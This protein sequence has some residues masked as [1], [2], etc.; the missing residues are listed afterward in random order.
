M[1]PA[2]I[3]VDPSTMNTRQPV[4]RRRSAWLSPAAMQESS[5]GR[6]SLLTVGVIGAVLLGLPAAAVAA[7]TAETAKTAGTP[8]PVTQATQAVGSGTAMRPRATAAVEQYWTPQR[9]TTAKPK[10]APP[11]TPSQRARTTSAPTGNPGGIAPA[12][13]TRT[14]ATAPRLGGAASWPATYNQRPT[15]IVG[16]VFFT[17]NAGVNY[18]CSGAV[19]NSESKLVVWTA[20]HC[21]FDVIHYYC[22]QPQGYYHNWIFVPGYK[23]GLAP[24]GRWT[25]RELWTPRG[26][27]DGFWPTAI[28]Y[29]TGAAIMNLRNGQRIADVTGGFGLVWNVAGMQPAWDFGYPAQAPYNGSTLKYCWGGESSDTAWPWANRPLGLRCTLNGGAS[30]GPWLL[31]NPHTAGTGYINGQNSYSQPGDPTRIYSPYYGTA[32]GTLFNTVRYRYR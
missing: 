3:A 5:I 30:G 19:V 1:R 10:D 6:R 29:D 9:M 32:Q 28:P 17:D 20:G 22:S 21:V 4:G 14:A 23:N 7:P 31:G 26:Y 16:K 12:A 13:A 8:V 18:V 11:V 25:A 15:R 24:Y 2:L 27:C